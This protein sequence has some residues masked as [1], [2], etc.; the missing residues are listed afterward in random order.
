MSKMKSFVKEVVA[1]I[2]GDKDAVIAEKNYRKASSGVKQQ[3]AALEAKL[4]GDEDKVAA[5]QEDLNATMY[6]TTLIG[7]P[8]QYVKNIVSVKSRV[9][10][11]KEQLE[12]TQASIDFFKKLLGSFDEETEAA[13]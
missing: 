5:A 7:D 2:A 10:S 11:A 3:I 1:R 4:V 8:E 6:P 13:A 9:D 12:A